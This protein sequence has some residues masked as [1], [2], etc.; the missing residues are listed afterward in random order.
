MKTANKGRSLVNPPP[1]RRTQRP[2]PQ[3][4]ASNK[5]TTPRKSRGGGNH[6]IWSK[7]MEP[8]KPTNREGGFFQSQGRRSG[9]ALAVTLAI[10][11]GPG[12]QWSPPLG[13]AAALR[14]PW[15]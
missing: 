12:P 1:E 14:A 3:P 2:A 9:P 4:R 8:Q 13:P 10:L 6:A 15:H 7:C 5:K 11:R